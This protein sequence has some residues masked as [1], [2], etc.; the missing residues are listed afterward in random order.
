MKREKT[1]NQVC[2]H[3]GCQ[4]KGEFPAP[5][6]RTDLHTYQWFC[7]KHIREFNAKW[8]YYADFSQDEIYEAQ[9]KDFMWGLDTKPM[10][11]PDYMEKRLHR[12]AQMWRGFYEADQG[13][14]QQPP[15]KQMDQAE[16][17]ARAVLGVDDEASPTEI[18]ATFRTLVKKHHPDANPDNRQQAEERF[19]VISQAYIILKE[20]DKRRSA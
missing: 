7:L 10:A 19:K 20:I 1:D 9:K 3:P 15:K 12:L 13:R 8:N 2:A 5:Q 17:D 11:N 14:G 18:K 4:E 6:S 16:R